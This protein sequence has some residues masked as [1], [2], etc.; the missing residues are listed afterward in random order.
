MPKHAFIALAFLLLPLLLACESDA[1][2]FRDSPEERLAATQAA[3]QTIAQSQSDP[4]PAEGD[5]EVAPSEPVHQASAEHPAATEQ[6]DGAGGVEDSNLPLEA[7]T[8]LDA[9]LRLRYPQHDEFAVF[10]ITIE[11]DIPGLRM[12]Y[13]IGQAPASGHV[14]AIFEVE[15]NRV[16]ARASLT[17]NPGDGLVSPRIV[18]PFNPK[19]A[20][21]GEEK[22]FLRHGAVGAHGHGADLIRWNPNDAGPNALSIELSWSSALPGAAMQL[23]DYDADGV[24]EVRLDDTNA[25]VFCYA[26]G[27]RETGF[28]IARWDGDHLVVAPL[29]ELAPS[30]LEPARAAVDFAIDLAAANLW[31]DAIDAIDLAA[32][33]APG[34]AT[35]EWNAILIRA[36]AAE[37]EAA[38]GEIY[39]LLTHL[40]AGQFQA[41]VASLRS[42]LPFDLLDL[43]GPVTAGTPADGWETVVAETLIRTSDD[44]LALRPDLAPALFLRGL[45]RFWLTPDQADRAITDINA[46]A[47]IEP[48]EP[49]YE[50]V[51]NLLTP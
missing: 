51:A 15:E 31:L 49:L 6:T 18:Q 24:P 7:P 2:P 19:E 34:N 9:F 13:S 10:P 35:I 46:A 39:P 5:A 20:S 22:W 41:A 23:I 25:Y 36:R 4:A 42:I 38:A 16:I 50:T 12:A 37:R 1:S 48:G 40:Y 17:F 47:A 3:E 44:A 28:Q 32:R 43:Y 14:A 26:C 30:A 11:P 21:W 33:L 8:Q 29:S 45:A 27:V